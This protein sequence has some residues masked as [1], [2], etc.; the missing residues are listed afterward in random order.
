MLRYYIKMKKHALLIG[1]N[2][3]NSS[4]ELNGAINDTLNIKNMIKDKLGYNNIVFLN[5]YTD[6]RPT[7]SVILEELDNV[8][9]KINNGECDEFW[10][11]YS[12]HGY[13]TKDHSGDE[14]DGRDEVLIPLD[15]EDGNV[16]S[17]DELNQLFLKKITNK[18]CKIFCLIDCCH[19]GTQ[20]DLPY[21]FTNKKRVVLNNNTDIKCK[22]A[23]I[24]G[25]LD[26]EV[27]YDV[28]NANNNNQYSGAMTSSLI[29]A[30][31]NLDFNCSFYDL[32]K[33]MYDFL[34]E[35]NYDQSP[36]LS[37]NFDMNNN[38]LFCS[39]DLKYNNSSD[40]DL[41]KVK[42]KFKKVKNQRDK[43]IKKKNYYNRIL[44]YINYYIS[45]RR[46]ARYVNYLNNLYNKYLEYL[47]NVEKDIKKNNKQ[48]NKYISMLK[49][50]GK[51]FLICK[52]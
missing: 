27:S 45:N 13:Y 40:I 7:K 5:D 38:S 25:C 10:F 1:I 17:D 28:Y 35:K 8:V 34:H 19:S 2:Y 42:N 30:L 6:R 14:I 39:K 26:S 24:S 44:N 16:I 46:Y 4:C 48:I 22:V 15:Y 36:Q 52:L 3:V 33:H 12:G 49:K 47:K 51:P 50:S 9:N 18:N 32:V 20:F 43:L 29:N 23:L 21:L 37:C 11:H 41:D 31:N